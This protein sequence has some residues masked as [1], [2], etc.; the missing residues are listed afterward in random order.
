MRNGLLGQIATPPA[1]TL[2][3]EALLRMG[4][5][6]WNGAH[7]L[8]S[9]ALEQP[10]MQRDARLL[11]SE[12]CQALGEHEAA[13][14]HLSEALAQ[15]PLT[16]RGLPG[17]DGGPAPPRVRRRAVPGAVPAHQPQAQLRDQPQTP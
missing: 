7:L 14:Q 15:N 13:L 1:G 11:L 17:A 4:E 12:V 8:L 5:A 9:E 10:T 16:S 3:H 2:L 6:D